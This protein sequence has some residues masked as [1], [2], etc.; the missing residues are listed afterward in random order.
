VAAVERNRY[1][2]VILG[3]GPGGLAAAYYLARQGARALVVE[4]SRR[5]GGLMRG[6]QR[7]DFRLDL[8]RKDLHADRFPDVHALWTA[9]LGADYVACPR[10]V[11]VLYGGRILEKCN[12]PKGRRRGMSAAQALRLAA[13]ALWSQLK[14]GSRSARTQEEY[15]LLRHGRPYYEYFV[16]GF[17]KKF[18][19]RDP[20]RVPPPR[21]ITEIPRFA[22]LRERLARRSDGHGN[23]G[24]GSHHPALGTQ[25]I[26]DALWRGAQAGGIEFAF[27]AE[28]VALNA[29]GGKLRSVV[30][31]HDGAEHTVH[32]GHAIA[33]LP[34]PLILRMLRPGAPAGL[35][36]PPHDEKA[37]KKST[38]LVYLFAEGESKFPHSWLEVTDPLLRMG[39]VTN[40][41]AWGGRMV[42]PGKTA[43]CIEFFALEG[44]ELMM[45][46]KEAL[47]ELAVSEAAQNGL[48]DRARVSDHLVLQ[49]PHA[50][51]T[52]LFTDWR[53][54]WMTQARGYLRGIEGLLD[55]NRPGMDRAC[56][57][58]IDAAEACLAGRAMSERSLE[59]TERPVEPSKQAPGRVRRY[60]YGT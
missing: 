32:T 15:Y 34:V 47:L 11:G 8:G 7:G 25:Q 48:V 18:E 46:S 45:L 30:I 17:E 12:G 60:A 35:S 53:T 31:R 20:S 2:A 57:A 5:V 4:R 55:I 36:T 44:D 16:R 23:P 3:A 52:T 40:Y 26:V 9:L 28:A 19:S 41:S 56:L 51:A 29:E 33:G 54:P 14:P 49:M 21:G 10:H 6:V 27:E 59:D 24:A 22:I 43:L 38:A 39:R 37:L 42:P 50:N 13:G 1:D 58:G